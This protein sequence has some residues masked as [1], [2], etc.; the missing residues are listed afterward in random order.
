MSIGVQH[1]N[2][3]RVTGTMTAV[4]PPGHIDDPEHGWYIICLDHGQTCC[5]GWTLAQAR[6]MKSAPDEWCEVCMVG[7]DGR[8]GL[9]N[10]NE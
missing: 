8:D 5:G 3:A 9:D 2:K 7:P 4:I 10:E 6:Y 1:I